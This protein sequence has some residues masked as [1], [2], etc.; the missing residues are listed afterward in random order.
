M[1]H[2]EYYHKHFNRIRE[3]GNDGSSYDPRFKIMRVGGDGFRSQHIPG[4]LNI[5]AVSDYHY[6]I[7]SNLV[8][9]NMESG[10]I[11]LSYLGYNGI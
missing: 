2:P 5:G 1:A 9:T 11:L 4:C 6:K 8:D 3:W 7:D 10:E